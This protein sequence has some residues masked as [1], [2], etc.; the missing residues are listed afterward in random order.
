MIQPQVW[1]FL[2]HEG[3]EP[4]NNAGERS[5]RHAVMWQGK[6][7][8]KGRASP[9]SCSLS[10]SASSVLRRS[11]SKSFSI[12]SSHACSPYCRSHASN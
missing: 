5:L 1:T 2:Q 12:C 4:T 6:V 10:T 8:H 9:A 3:I 11:A 7:A